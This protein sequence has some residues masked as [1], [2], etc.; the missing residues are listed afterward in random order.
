LKWKDLVQPGTQLPTPWDKDEYDAYEKAIQ[1]R[2]K[3]LR[4]RHAPE[5]EMDALFKEELAW[6]RPFLARPPHGGKVGLFEGADYRAK[7]L[8]R[9]SA[10]CIM[11]TRNPEGFCRVCARAIER[12]IDW[13][14]GR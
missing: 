2:R 9:P 6:T 14:T 3:A 8:Y 1:E 5:A 12:V 10:D 7:G 13:V 11:F 4:A